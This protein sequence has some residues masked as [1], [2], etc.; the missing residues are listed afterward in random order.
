[1]FVDIGW[2]RM[3]T[4]DIH[5]DLCDIALSM[6]APSDV[7]SNMCGNGHSMAFMT[8]HRSTAQ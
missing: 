1:M 4:Y 7:K 3:P 5:F 6:I 2:G 8:D